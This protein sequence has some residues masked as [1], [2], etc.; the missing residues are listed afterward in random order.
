MQ[1][2]KTT[3]PRARIDGFLLHCRSCDP[4]DLAEGSYKGKI[5]LC[6][7]QSGFHPND[8]SGP[9]LAGAAGAVIVGRAP[10]VA[11]ALPLPG[12]VLTQDQFNEIL[13]Y[14]NSTR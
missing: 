11:F 6:P 13:A 7:P 12:L 8:G 1:G 5:V 2:N 3:S 14:V 10:D 4:D 9:L